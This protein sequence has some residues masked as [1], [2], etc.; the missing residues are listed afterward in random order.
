M[1]YLVCFRRSTTNTIQKF[2]W[3]HRHR[4]ARQTAVYAYLKIKQLLLSVF[5]ISSIPVNSEHVSVNWTIS[6]DKLCKLHISCCWMDPTRL[7][8]KVNPN[9]D[10]INKYIWIHLFQ[11]IIHL[12]IDSNLQHTHNICEHIIMWNN[13]LGISILRKLIMVSVDRKI[14][15]LL[16]HKIRKLTFKKLI[17]SV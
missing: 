8:W 10:L 15:S 6:F 1:K 2:I 4:P 11:S 7:W 17:T 16:V 13:S 14:F 9:R 5:A 12:C 3:S